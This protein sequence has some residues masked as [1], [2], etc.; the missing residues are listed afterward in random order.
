MKLYVRILLPKFRD[1][2]P[3]HVNF[4]RTFLAQQNLHLLPSS[5]QYRRRMTRFQWIRRLWDMDMAL[6]A[7]HHQNS[8]CQKWKLA[9]VD[10]TPVKFV[11]EVFLIVGV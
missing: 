6:S 7:G 2:L 1:G 3:D 4:P 10:F 9:L 5:Q 11:V 8:V